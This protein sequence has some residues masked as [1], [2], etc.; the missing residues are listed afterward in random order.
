VT[1]RDAVV[2]D[3]DMRIAKNRSMQDQTT[4]IREADTRVRHIDT[5]IASIR[6]EQQAASEAVEGL[7]KREL[8]LIETLGSIGRAE[9]DL[10]RAASDASLLGSVPCGGEGDY[11]A[12]QFLT[13][14]EAAR[15]RI[16]TLEATIGPKD[17]TRTDLQD[18]RARI[19]ALAAEA[20][21]AQARVQN[22]QTAR[23]TAYVVAQML[24]DVAAAEERI[25]AHEQRKRDAEADA[26]RRTAD[27]QARASTRREELQRRIDEARAALA[28]Q[29]VLFDA[30]AET[31]REEL[32]LQ[33]DRLNQEME[34]GAADGRDANDAMARTVDASTR[35][36]EQSALL[37][38][39]RQ[40]W[41]ETTAALGR[42]KAEHDELARRVAALRARRY[43]MAT[44]DARLNAL[45][46]D[47]VEWQLLAKALGRD[48]L[49]ML[50][51][52]GAGP[53]VSAYCTDLL[54][55]TPAGAHFSVDLVT[56]EPKTTKGKDGSTHK[57][58]FELKV[59]D[60]SRGGESRD[61]TDLSGGEQ[62]I[63][64]ECLKSA[65]ALL[66]N[67]RQE[68]PI[69]TC[70]R[71]ETTGALDAENALHYIDMLRRVHKL[72]GFHHI[73][74][75]THNPDA[76]AMADAQVLFSDGRIAVRLPPFGD[77][78]AA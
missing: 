68:H 19:V 31:R 1:E 51:I 48:G 40:E 56:Q 6:H 55:H 27:A 63:V 22:L 60:A 2:A 46:A 64:D 9:L 25:A 35:W 44:V 20:K 57:D 37:T 29:L 58:A 8:V 10:Q 59:F 3:A 24:P 18:V 47:V 11:A 77:R 30:R 71:D 54:Q 61:L 4:A 72:G 14:A 34:V 17:H 26:T 43:E 23:E 78:V 33:L 28:R 74:F 73:L 50:E 76:A 41:D 70:W 53:A 75:V 21:S 36:A 15:A 67:E 45:K 5:D 32:Q 52:D 13:N 66:V 39:T 7:R 49:Q 69:R 65:I 42:V 62:I 38:L 12:C 16:P